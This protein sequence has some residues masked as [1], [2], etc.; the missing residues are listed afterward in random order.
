[1]KYLKNYEY[2]LFQDY[3]DGRFYPGGTDGAHVGD[4]VILD[5]DTVDSCAP[6][7]TDII[8]KIVNIDEEASGN[9]FQIKFT[10]KDLYKKNLVDQPKYWF[11]DNDI[12]HYGKKKEMILK[13]SAEQYNL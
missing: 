11:F 3:Y 6:S 13:L 10:K 2:L 9:Y 5:P 1:M 8:G 4:Y 12:L 7:L